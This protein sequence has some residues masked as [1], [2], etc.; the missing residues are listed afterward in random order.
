M[1]FVG[2]G[3]VS[4]GGEELWTT[5][6]YT[7][8]TTP[9]N[10][11]SHLHSHTPQHHLTPTGGTPLP[12][13][14]PTGGTPLPHLTPTGGTPLPHLTPTEGTPLPHLT[15]RGEGTPLPH[16][17]SRG[18]PHCLTSHLGGAPHCLTSHLLGAPHS[19]IPDIRLPHLTQ[20][21]TI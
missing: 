5:P 15:H 10:I 3:V 20:W 1:T 4:Q 12:H 21:W 7:Y 11:T 8:I 19:I 14:T 17:T 9:H 6:S 18:A 16:L 13:L 2:G